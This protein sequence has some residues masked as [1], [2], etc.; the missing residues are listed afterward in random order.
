MRSFPRRRP[1]LTGPAAVTAALATLAALATGC[2]LDTSDGDAEPGS[3]AENAAL[4]G[5]SFTV[6]SKEFT[7]QL[8]LCQITGLALRSTG[9]EVSEECG[10]QGSNTT[11]SALESGDI[12][13]YW[14]YTGT[15][16]INFLGHTEPIDDPA[17]QYDSAAREDL[18]E[19]GI[20]WLTPAPANNTYAIVVK[21]S[22]AEELGVAS[23]SDYARLVADDPGRATL[24]IASEFAGRDDGL[25]GLEEAYGFHVAD[26]NLATLAEGAIYHA[27][28]EN[29]PCAFGEAATTDG[30]IEA[31]DLT[32]LTDD[33][34]FFPVYNP[35][36]TVRSSVLEAHPDLESIFAAIAPALTD[37]VLQGLNARVDIDGEDPADVARDWLQ[38]EGF[39]GG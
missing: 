33:K 11:R 7:E 13:M 29:D 8:V 12:D 14:E 36:L 27:V 38:Q 35:A 26:G 34:H 2:S 17:E 37:E 1:L 28:A 6:G 19:N 9:A 4:D 25:P 21:T 22:T 20:A 10:L 30:R 16:W 31:L 32:V 15:A 39:I 5:A 24:C 18:S 23:L 3:L